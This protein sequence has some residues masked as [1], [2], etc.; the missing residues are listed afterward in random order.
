MVTL[1]VIMV[2]KNEERNGNPDEMVAFTMRLP[3]WV[4]WELDDWADEKY[5]T[6]NKILR[7]LIIPP[8]ERRKKRNAEAEA[9]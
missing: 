8:C 1:G 9:A 5:T 6:R 3:R 7:D 2:N 4:S